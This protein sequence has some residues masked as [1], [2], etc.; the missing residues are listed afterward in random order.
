MLALSVAI[1]H[2]EVLHLQAANWRGHPAILVSVIVNPAELA[3]LPAD[4]HTLK[5]I[6]SVNQVAGVTAFGEKQVLVQCLR[7]YRM[8]L[9]IILHIFQRE[10]ALGDSRQVLYPI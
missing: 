9:D 10:S 8:P 3:N 7:A 1:L 5:Q 4:G 2:P 6:I